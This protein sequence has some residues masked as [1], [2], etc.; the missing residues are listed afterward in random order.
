MTIGA[1]VRDEESA[2]FFEATAAGVLTVQLCG[3]CGHRQFPLTFVP[4]VIRCRACGSA[5]LTWVPVS[6]LG[7]LV[8]WTH[9]HHKPAQ[10]G[11]P[12]P[13]TTIAVV[14]LD[15]GPWVHAQLRS[16]PPNLHVGLRVAVNFDAAEGGESLPVFAP[17]S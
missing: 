10:D 5:Q 17:V 6:G 11:T 8:T 12:R 14:E 2:D 13:P 16:A 1:I 3:E 7:G 15:E 4:S 9:V